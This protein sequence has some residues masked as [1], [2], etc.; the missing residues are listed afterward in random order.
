M[1]SGISPLSILI[2]SCCWHTIRFIGAYI[3][4]K[5][6][7]LLRPSGTSLPHVAATNRPKPTMSGLICVSNRLARAAGS[8]KNSL[9][10]QGS[11]F[12]LAIDPIN[13]S[14]KAMLRIF[15]LGRA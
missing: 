5:G 11:S 14:K 10:P 2:G 12:C 4:V 6:C 7:Q 3:P 8:Q 15:Q 9:Y 13:S 1:Q